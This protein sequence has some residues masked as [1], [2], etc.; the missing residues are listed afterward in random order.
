LACI[1][2]GVRKSL[3]ISQEDAIRLNLE[4]SERVFR[5]PDCEEGVRA[6]FEKRPPSFK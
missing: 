6:F 5:S 2:E 4:L 3:E 1:K